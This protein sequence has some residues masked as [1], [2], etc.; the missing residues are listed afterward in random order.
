MI[1]TIKQP[2][3]Q[4]KSLD[5]TLYGLAARMAGLESFLRQNVEEPNG[6][7]LNLLA[8][9]AFEINYALCDCAEKVAEL[10]RGAA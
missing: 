10:T 6:N 4:A 1:A 7:S 2:A 9:V 8:E 3:G 5:S